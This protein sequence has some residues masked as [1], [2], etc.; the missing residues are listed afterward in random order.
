MSAS[1]SKVEKLKQDLKASIEEA[2]WSWF[3]PH[4]A[5]DAVFLVHSELEMA[6]VGAHIAA[7]SV[8]EI[9][10]WLTAGKLAKPDQDKIQYWDSVPDK[11]FRFL[12]VQPYVLIQFLDH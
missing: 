10:A 7:D 11:R 8:Q 1:P 12:I 5:R 4:V 6:E 9:S 2:P 3:A